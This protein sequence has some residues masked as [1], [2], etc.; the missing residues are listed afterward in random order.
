MDCS[1][2]IELL[3]EYS[4]GSL[5]DDDILFVKTHLSSCQD[6]NGVFQD[7]RLIVQTAVALR[8]DNGI[9]YPDEEIL[10]QRVSARRIIH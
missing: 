2:S 9:A 1:R 8:S 5:G 7:L 6:C 3:S 4:A 10:W